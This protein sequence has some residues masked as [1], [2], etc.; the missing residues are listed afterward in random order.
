MLYKSSGLKKI[1]VYILCVVVIFF[2]QYLLVTFSAY[3]SLVNSISH[4]D[5]FIANLHKIIL[6]Y[7]V[8]FNVTLII[9]LNIDY[10]M[11]SLPTVHMPKKAQIS[12]RSMAFHSTSHYRTLEISFIALS[13]FCLSLIVAFTLLH[14]SFI[15]R[16]AM[17]LY[18]SN[19]LF[20]SLVTQFEQINSII[21]GGL[22]GPSAFSFWAAFQPLIK[23]LISIDP[24]WKYLLCQNI[25]AWSVSLISFAYV[26]YCSRSTKKT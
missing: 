8:P 22:M 16:F 21:V 2:A 4:S 6:F 15:H 9:L 23:Q 19:S 10:I 20:R 26:K 25:A 5:I 7:L 13:L 3:E 11:R 1:S 14:P 12:P 24:V 18:L 17:N